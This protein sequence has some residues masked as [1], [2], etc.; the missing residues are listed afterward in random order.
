MNKISKPL[1]EK[2]TFNISS[3]TNN[4]GNFLFE[5]IFHL[6]EEPDGLAEDEDEDKRQQDKAALRVGRRFP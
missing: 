5:N 6:E 3:I 1:I 4:I 2:V